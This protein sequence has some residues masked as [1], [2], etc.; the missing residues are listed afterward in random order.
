MIGHIGVSDLSSWRIQLRAYCKSEANRGGYLIYIKTKAKSNSKF[1]LHLRVKDCHVSGQSWTHINQEA[2]KLKSSNSILQ[3]ETQIA[4]HS[5]L[6]KINAC[7]QQV[8]SCLCM[9]G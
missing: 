2:S 3:L 1:F 4:M 9:R 8:D 7:K 6:S 5:S